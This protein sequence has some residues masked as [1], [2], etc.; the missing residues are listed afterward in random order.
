MK[1]PHKFLELLDN[2]LNM[3]KVGGLNEYEVGDKDIDKQYNNA[4]Y[5]ELI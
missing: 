1:V 5:I 4:H 2:L 3:I